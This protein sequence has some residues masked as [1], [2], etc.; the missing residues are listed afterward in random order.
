MFGCAL[1]EIVPAV[2]AR[3]TVPD[4]LAPATALAVAANVTSPETFAPATAFAVPANVAKFI[5]P[6]KL[7]TAIFDMPP[8]SPVIRP[9]VT[10]KAPVTVNDVNVP[11]DVMLG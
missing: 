8:P 9:V 1:V 4:T 7:P 6:T 10:P 5:V 11:V 3:G 2:V